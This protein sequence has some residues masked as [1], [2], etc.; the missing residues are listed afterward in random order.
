MS[1]LLFKRLKPTIHFLQM[2]EAVNGFEKFLKESLMHF[3]HAMSKSYERSGNFA[4]AFQNLNLANELQI[5]SRVS[6]GRSLY[7]IDQDRSL[8]RAIEELEES[9]PLAE[10][11]ELYNPNSIPIFILGLPRSE[12]RLLNE[13]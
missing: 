3:R 12:P 11:L 7:N 1:T 2:E 13:L 5:E 6:D 10:G 4:D 9:N 8:F